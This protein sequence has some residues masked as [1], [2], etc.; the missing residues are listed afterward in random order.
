[1][2][3]ATICLHEY[4]LFPAPIKTSSAPDLWRERNDEIDELARVEG[5]INLLSTIKEYI[6]TV[7]SIT[8]RLGFKYPKIPMR[9]SF[10]VFK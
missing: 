1:M 7:S 6:N 5:L 8:S 3:D 10:P 9:K 2:L 4:N